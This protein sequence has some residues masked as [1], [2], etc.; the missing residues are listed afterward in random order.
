MTLTFDLQ[1]IHMYNP[2]VH[3]LN[4][5]PVDGQGTC[6]FYKVLMCLILTDLVDYINLLVLAS[7]EN[8]G[9]QGDSRPS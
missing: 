1:N 7:V 6:Y 9:F 5:P 2:D 8:I 4:L 3:R